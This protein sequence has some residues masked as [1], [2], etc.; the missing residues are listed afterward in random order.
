MWSVPGRLPAIARPAPEVT[1]APTPL[2][3]PA[4]A[5]PVLAGQVRDAADGHALPSAQVII[6]SRSFGADAEGRFEVTLDPGAYEVQAVVGGYVTARFRITLSESGGR[7]EYYVDLIRRR[8]RGV[9]RED[10]TQKPIAEA[11]LVYGPASARSGP[12]GSFESG[13]AR[14]PGIGGIAPAAISRQRCRWQR[15]RRSM[16]LSEHSGRR[17]RSRWSLAC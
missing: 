4:P 7:S 15:C 16:R 6:G 12:E 11:S 13:R 9:V 10:G 17:W 5:D 3:T 1:P 2:I 14:T 8:L